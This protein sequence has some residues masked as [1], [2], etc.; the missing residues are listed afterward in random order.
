MNN[1][2]YTFGEIMALE[3]RYRAT[4]VN[5]L[6]GFKSLVLI[7]TKSKAG[8]TNLAIF[9]SFFHIGANPPLFGFIVRPDSAERHTL[10][11]IMDTG[12][13]TVNHVHEDF[14]KKAHQC[15]ARYASNISEFEA[16]GLEEEYLQDFA[17]PY[18]K[19]SRVKI[20]AE[21]RERKDLSINGTIL[22]L[23]QILYV[24]FP[25]QCM[26]PDGFLNLEKAGTLT[27]SGLDSYHTTNSIARL[28]Y[29]KTDKL[30]DVIS[31]KDET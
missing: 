14:Y 18:V 21:L 16:V 13:F 4:L 8:T 25:N 28:T 6:G 20:G 9:N 22:M 23:A 1:T 15:S 10:A 31:L 30:P 11:N 5:S 2:A 17:A 27:C 7:G 24:S 29:A 12:I 26:M 19:E 3:Q